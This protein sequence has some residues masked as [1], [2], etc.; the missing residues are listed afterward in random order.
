MKTSVGT[1]SPACVT[2]APLLPLAAHGMLAGHRAAALEE[3]L[4]GCTHCR[5]ELATYDEVDT[6]LRQA[7]APPPGARPPFSQA[8]IAGLLARA[9][10]RAGQPSRAFGWPTG[11][12]RRSRWLAGLPAVAAV[13]LVAVLAQAL[14]TWHHGTSGGPLATREPLPGNIELK[15]LSMVSPT[16]GWAVGNTTPRPDPRYADS[17]DTEPVILHY[18]NGVW[19]VVPNPP[20]VRSYLVS[21]ILTSISMDSSTDGWAVGHV[22]YL[23]IP[24]V[25]ADGAAIGM[26]L[27]CTGG[28]WTVAE[29]NLGYNPTSIFMR[30]ADDGWIVSDLDGLTLHYDGRAWTPVKVPL[31]SSS[32]VPVAVT[33]TQ[34]GDVWVAAT[35]FGGSSGSSGFDG[36]APEV[37]LHYDGQTWSP[38]SLP[39]P[40]ARITSL[41]M[42]SPTEGWAAGVLPRPERGSVGGDAT[43]PDNA[44]ILHY[45]NSTWEEQ[46][47][48]PGPVDSFTTFNGIAMMSASEG[49]AVG[50]GG[51]IVH[52]SQGTWTRVAS[53][54][55]QALQS[56]AMVSAAEG[57]AVGDHGTVLHYARGAW[58]QY[59]G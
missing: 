26:I 6:A 39:D 56:V 44:L 16:E 23:T 1:P 3:H 50:T 12:P 48:F 47:R 37:V 13:V 42:T 9:G 29:D 58:S 59:R 35:D 4:A 24:G 52:Y 18:L 17:L 8:E 10:E 14:F 19:G 36:D 30:A 54:T 31:R 34:D 11:S 22:V 51:L 28:Q 33:G 41:V 20:R 40:H 27:H 5:D 46:A 32:L 21:M 55:S 57:W 49:W 2:F 25:V 7:F 38:E 43:K 45:R 53:P 15:S